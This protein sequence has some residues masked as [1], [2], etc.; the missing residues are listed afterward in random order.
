MTTYLDDPATA[1]LATDCAA[2]N[3]PLRD[4]VSVEAG[5]GPDCRKKH[6]YGQ[7]Q[8]DADWSAVDEALAGT[9]DLAAAIAAHRGD[10]HRAA[11][12]L[13]HRAACAARD[14]RAP[15]VKAVAALEFVKLAAALA[16][17]AG[18]VVEVQPFEDGLLA[19]RAP[20]NATFNEVLRGLRIGARWNREAPGNRRPGAWV[21]PSDMPAKKALLRALRQ[22][23][24]GAMLV[25]QH[26]VTQL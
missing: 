20:F 23:F 6:G 25:S 26:G 16:R 12:V 18:D 3:R 10:A 2:C 7:A 5:I 8:G 11:N 24:A 1:L 9:P 17:G 14:E 4:A 21:V 15:H 22:T 13:V 19:V